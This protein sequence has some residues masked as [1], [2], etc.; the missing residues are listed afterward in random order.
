MIALP[1]SFV[2]ISQGR[3][4]ERVRHGMDAEGLCRRISNS[5]GARAIL[6]IAHWCD[7]VSRG[8]ALAKKHDNPLCKQL[9][10]IWC[11]VGRKSLGYCAEEQNPLAKTPGSRN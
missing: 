3:C 4:V 2:N 11:T 8:I 5:R 10:T 6:A 9:K 1:A 7:G